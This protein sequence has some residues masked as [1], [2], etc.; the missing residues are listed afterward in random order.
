MKTHFA[1]Q[2]GSGE[3]VWKIVNYEQPAAKPL[4]EKFKIQ[5]PVVVLAG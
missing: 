4:A 3:V 1:S 2:L 5:M